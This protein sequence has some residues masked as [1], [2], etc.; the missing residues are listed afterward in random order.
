MVLM[1]QHTDIGDANRHVFVDGTN[2]GAPAGGLVDLQ[3]LDLRTTDPVHV[4]MVRE[5]PASRAGAVVS[6]LL[7]TPSLNVPAVVRVHAGTGCSGTGLSAEDPATGAQVPAEACVDGGQVFLGRNVRQDDAGK[8]F[9]APGD[10]TEEKYVIAHELG[11]ALDILTNGA[12]AGGVG[13]TSTTWDGALCSCDHVRGANS[14]HCLQSKM[15]QAGGYLEGFA[16][17]VATA[18]MNPNTKRDVPFVYYKEVLRPHW[19]P[20]ARGNVKV[21]PPVRVKAGEPVAWLKN[22][23]TKGVEADRSTE[24]DWMTFLWGIHQRETAGSIDY[25]TWM[26][27]V[28]DGWCNGTNCT[29]GGTLSWRPVRDNAFARFGYNQMNPRMQRMDDLGRDSAVDH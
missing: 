17:F 4:T 6:T 13:Y 21:F 25:A 16:H 23:C 14:L 18:V 3:E 1:F 22:R 29:G 12:S 27:I 20:M 7:T 28:R 9:L 19:N 10:T 24:Y 11:H 8:R 26:S 15:N 5:T 2:F